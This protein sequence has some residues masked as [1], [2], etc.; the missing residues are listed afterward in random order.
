MFSEIQKLMGSN[1]TRFKINTKSYII[2]FIAKILL[3]LITIPLMIKGWGLNNFGIWIFLTSIPHILSIANIDVVQ[4]V[5]QE[6]ILNKNKGID[7]LNTLFSNSFSCTLLNSLIFGIFYSLVFIL[8]FDKFE[9]INDYKYNNLSSLILLIIFGYFF[10]TISQ[11]LLISFDAIG[12][13][14]KTVLINNNFNI[15]LTLLI[16]IS[17]FFFSN[18]IIAALIYCIICFLKF[19]F[20]AY[21]VKNNDIKFL[22]NRINYKTIKSIFIISK[23][24]YLNNF[25]G[26]IYL[27]GI[28]FIIGVFY[29]AEIVSLVHSLNTMFRWSVSRL[30]SIFIMPFNYEFPNYFKDGKY[31][32]LSK[33]FKAQLRLL[34]IIL[35][36]YLISS[37]LFGSFIFNIWVEKIFDDFSV[38][39]ILIVVENT[40]YIFG[41]NYLFYLKS[42]NKFYFFSKI[43]LLLS[44][45]VIISLFFLGSY[46]YNIESFI[47]IL[48]IRSFIALIILRKSYFL[49]KKEFN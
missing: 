42:I 15:V 45:F 31:L 14:K 26:V 47:Y 49:I 33:L 20:T 41:N 13:I 1:F 22:I 39:L 5:K 24:Y 3:Q 35:S 28:N 48:L 43:D 8:F 2:E 12:Q 34:I 21:K 16:A 18:L 27:S 19:L 7:Y 25:S 44:F 17:G 38:L 36:V 29:S 46:N 23:S 37:I 11:N 6:L 10:E 32:L 40:I 9:I 30:S 4:A